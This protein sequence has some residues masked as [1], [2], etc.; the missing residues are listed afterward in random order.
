MRLAKIYM[1]NF[2]QQLGMSDAPVDQNLWYGI[3]TAG[4]QDLSLDPLDPSLD[5]TPLIIGLAVGVGVLLI[6]ILIVICCIV[7]VTLKTK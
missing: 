2:N 7:G 1:V 3:I 6:V 4:L 5:Y